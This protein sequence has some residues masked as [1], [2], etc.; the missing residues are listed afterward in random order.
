MRQQ[1]EKK[2]LNIILD[3]VKS[4]ENVKQLRQYEDGLNTYLGK[5]FGTLSEIFDKVK[6]AA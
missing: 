2:M 5:T 4:V 1:L 6:A 3:E